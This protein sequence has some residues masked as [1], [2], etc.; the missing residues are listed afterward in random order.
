ME[1]RSVYSWR[2]FKL[3]LAELADNRSVVLN[4]EKVRQIRKS[5][6]WENFRNEFL[7]CMA[8]L[9][10]QVAVSQRTE[11][12]NLE[13]DNEMF[14]LLLRKHNIANKYTKIKQLLL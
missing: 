13:P 8:E 1:K 14:Q 10:G 6:E 12:K 5:D 9:H 4:G 7:P 2:Y 11:S 3:F